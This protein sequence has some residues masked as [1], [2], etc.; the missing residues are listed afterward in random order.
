MKEETGAMKPLP[1]G[2]GLNGWV[3]NLNEFGAC[4]FKEQKDYTCHGCCRSC[5]GCGGQYEQHCPGPFMPVK[6]DVST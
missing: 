1:E 2:Y 5:P 3:C 4:R 6:K